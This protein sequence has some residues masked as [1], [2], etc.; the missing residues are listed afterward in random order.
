MQR[1]SLIAGLA[2]LVAAQACGSDAPTQPV[3]SIQLQTAESPT[4]SL[5]VRTTLT[6]TGTVTAFVARCGEQAL[7]T[8][9]VFQSNAWSNTAAPTC[10]STEPAIEIAPGASIT[11]DYTVA[12]AGRYRSRVTISSKSDLTNS[13][14]I[15]GSALDVD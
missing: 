11:A 2:L 5:S 3:Q 12:A 9:Q 4:G 6:N 1:R 8:T 13:R 10:A 15:T 7:V 14:L